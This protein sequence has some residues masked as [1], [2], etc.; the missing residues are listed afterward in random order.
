MAFTL[1]RSARATPRDTPAQETETHTERLARIRTQLNTDNGHV[2]ARGPD[3]Q[4]AADEE[5]EQASAYTDDDDND[6]EEEQPAARSET[7]L[8]SPRRMYGKDTAAVPGHNGTKKGKRKRDS[9]R[10]RPGKRQRAEM[11][12]RLMAG[13]LPAGGV[14]GPADDGQ[15]SGHVTK[16]K[17]ALQEAADMA[18]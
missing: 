3:E 14:E 9:E 2:H 11:K 15:G 8:D 18:Q 7:G 4:A 10:K 6:A 16:G 5:A 12:Q 1:L 17:H 13:G